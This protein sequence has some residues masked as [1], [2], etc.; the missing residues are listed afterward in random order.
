MTPEAAAHFALG[1]QFAPALPQ[2]V[3][4]EG[5]AYAQPVAEAFGEGGPIEGVVVGVAL[6]PAS[7]TP[8]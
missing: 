4:I 3:P 6:A 1:C 2:V 5:V 7:K 8:Y